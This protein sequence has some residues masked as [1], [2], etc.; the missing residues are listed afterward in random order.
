MSDV[1]L[2]HILYM[3]I[4]T[5]SFNISFCIRVYDWTLVNISLHSCMYS[6]QGMVEWGQVVAMTHE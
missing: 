3:Y 2:D 4:T 6:I 5:I 1:A